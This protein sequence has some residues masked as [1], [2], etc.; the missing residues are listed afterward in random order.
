M[1]IQAGLMPVDE[2]NMTKAAQ[3]KCLTRKSNANPAPWSGLTGEDYD[4]GDQ[5]ARYITESTLLL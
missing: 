5:A 4:D 1:R 3:L 2:E